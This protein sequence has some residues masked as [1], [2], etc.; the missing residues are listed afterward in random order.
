MSSNALNWYRKMGYD[1]FYSDRPVNRLRDHQQEVDTSMIGADVVINTEASAPSTAAMN[2]DR[3]MPLSAMN[4]TQMHLRVAAVGTNLRSIPKRLGSMGPSRQLASACDS[5]DALY[6]A[7]REFTGCELKK[8]ATNTVIFDGNQSSEIMLIGEAPGATEDEKG[9]PFCGQSGKLLDNIIASIGLDRTMT[10]IT[11]TVF[12]RPPGNRRPTKEEL[13]IC[14]PFV[15]KHI[16]LIKPK[17]IIMVGSTAV[18]SLLNVT[19][20]ITQL[21][22]KYFDYTNEYLNGPIKTTAIFHPSYLL[23]Q[24]SQKKLMWFDMMGILEF[25]TSLER[26]IVR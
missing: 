24:Q 5:L 9:I 11:N 23:R 21:R 6:L 2:A 19:Q 1:E 8:S 18:E 26:P 13:A 22:R 3:A 15:E 16:A 20:P 14:S 17:L 12:W 7:I 25:I 10:Y 4:Y